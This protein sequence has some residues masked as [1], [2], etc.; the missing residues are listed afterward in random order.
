MLPV[1]QIGG[2]PFQ[3]E[4]AERLDQAGGLR[5]RNEFARRDIAALGVLPAH[6]RLKTGQFAIV[7]LDDRLVGQ[8]QLLALD[9]AA[10]IA[11]HLQTV[12]A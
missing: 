6:Q 4:H 7:K 8:R 12:G 2:S 11:F 3:G 5:N 10:K 1:H 9:G